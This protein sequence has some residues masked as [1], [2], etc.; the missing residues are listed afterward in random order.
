MKDD[1]VRR[2]VAFVTSAFSS[3]SGCRQYRED[4][5]RAREVAGPGA[6]EIDKL[7]VFYDHPGFV[8]PNAEHL[9]AALDGLPAGRRVAAR[10]VFTAHSIPVAMAR[11]CDY[12][13]QLWE[14]SRLVADAA[15][16]REWTLAYQSRSG[17]PQVPWLEPDILAV[18]TGAAAAGTSDLVVLPIGFVSDHLE[19]LH[20][21]DAE[22]M[23]TA[24]VLGVHL[25]RVPT[26][27]TAPGFVRMIRE[28]IHERTEPGPVRRGL[29]RFGPRPD[30]CPDDC[31]LPG[32]AAG[33]PARS[34]A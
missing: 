2:A 3:Y 34:S 1:G 28:L 29:G 27:G 24:R 16:V 13:A 6:P 7:R 17:P 26:M 9:R 19:V 23:A 12:E 10:V 14:A 15:G 22:A 32:V 25:T 30:V 31:C 33:E 20:D 18:V 21:L 4:L 11:R 8:Q 5:A